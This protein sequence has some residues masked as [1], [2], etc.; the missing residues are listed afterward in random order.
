MF[1]LKGSHC[2]RIGKKTKQKHLEIRRVV[3]E[4][5]MVWATTSY[6]L[7]VSAVIDWS[8]WRWKPHKVCKWWNNAL[9]IHSTKF[10]LG[11]GFNQ[12]SPVWKVANRYLLVSSCIKFLSTYLSHN[13][14]V[15]GLCVREV[16]ESC[17]QRVPWVMGAWCISS[18]LFNVCSNRGSRGL[19]GPSGVSQARLEARGWGRR[20]W[21]GRAAACES[22]QGSRGMFNV[23]RF[24]GASFSPYASCQLIGEMWGKEEGNHM[25][26]D[27]E[28]AGHSTNNVP[29]SCS[30]PTLE[31]LT[32]YV[33]GFRHN[34]TSKPL[35]KAV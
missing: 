19:G 24:G 29:I 9:L 27:R 21:N 12:L 25:E 30:K 10:I 31:S 23:P 26:A 15:Q 2:P 11:D 4:V 35:V 22:W 1:N 17:N 33:K 28:Y 6:L 18:F 5:H 14:V 20:S 16:E 3:N 32:H 13:H 34:N 7:V 8:V